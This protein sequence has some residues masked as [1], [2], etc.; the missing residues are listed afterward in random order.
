MMNDSPSRRKDR[1]RLMRTYSGYAGAAE[2]NLLYRFGVLE[3]L[4]QGSERGQS[5]KFSGGLCRTNKV[6]PA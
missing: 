6:T 4:S 1:P 5:S 2:S 3:R